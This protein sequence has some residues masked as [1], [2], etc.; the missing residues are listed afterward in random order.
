MLEFR[1]LIFTVRSGAD[2]GLPEVR[3]LALESLEA[4]AGSFIGLTQ[5]EPLTGDLL[6]LLL[7]HPQVTGR[8]QGLDTK[9]MQSV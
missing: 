6:L 5:L 2:A 8:L 4:L 3:D 9:T 1:A 7:L